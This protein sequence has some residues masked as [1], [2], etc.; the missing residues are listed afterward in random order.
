MGYSEPL[1]RAVRAEM[2]VLLAE[3]ERYASVAAALEAGVEREEIAC[4]L[5]V[6]TSKV[7]AWA[8]VHRDADYRQFLLDLMTKLA[9]EAGLYDEP[10]GFV[11]TR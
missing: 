4:A 6:N 1:K 11:E 7:T 2:A 3:R 9:Q 5:G 10:Q 8:A